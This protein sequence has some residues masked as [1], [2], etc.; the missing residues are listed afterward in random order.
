MTRIKS[1]LVGRYEV[2]YQDGTTVPVKTGIPDVVRWERNN[3]QTSAIG[4]QRA[5]T[6]LEI[7]F[8]ALRRQQ[9]SEVKVFDVW[10][11]SVAEVYT[12]GDEDAEDAEEDDGDEVPTPGALSS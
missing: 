9:L 2:Q 6:I 7:V 4:V 11:E 10:L 3:P 12:L 8:Y 5:T 1:G